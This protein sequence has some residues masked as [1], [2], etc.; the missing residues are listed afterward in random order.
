MRTPVDPTIEPDILRPEARRSVAAAVRIIR[1]I[2]DVG[3]YAWSDQFTSDPPEVQTA[4]VR[5]ALTEMAAQGGLGD[6]LHA[7]EPFIDFLAAR[8]EDPGPD[9]NPAFLNR[10]NGTLV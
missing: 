7:M 8:I 3:N 5:D 6:V 10:Q 9:G 1:A 4:R 2:R